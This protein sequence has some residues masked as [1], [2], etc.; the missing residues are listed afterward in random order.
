MRPACSIMTRSAV[1]HWGQVLGRKT[2][3]P[4]ELAAVEDGRMERL[5]RKRQP[6]Q[7]WRA[8]KLWTAYFDMPLMGGWHAFLEDYRGAGRRVWIDRDCRSIIAPLMKLFPLVLPF[9]GNEWDARHSDSWEL[10]KIEFAKTFQRRRQDRKPLGVAYVKWNH[11][12]A[13]IRITKPCE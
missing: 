7:E 6:A 8:C 12:D 9:T 10:W 4:N 3:I 1:V 5:E 2:P 13:P 11:H